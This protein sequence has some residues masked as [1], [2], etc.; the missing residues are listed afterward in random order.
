MR[1][2]AIIYPAADGASSH[3]EVK[4]VTYIAQVAPSVE[5][6]GMQQDF[7]AWP[8]DLSGCCW[9]HIARPPQESAPVLRE[10]TQREADELGHE[11]LAL[12]R[13]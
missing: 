9:F 7:G 2:R 3:D 10:L 1:L 13:E 12:Q 6:V 5:Y 8:R 11:L 4:T